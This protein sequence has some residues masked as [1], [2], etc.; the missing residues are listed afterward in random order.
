MRGQDAGLRHGQRGKLG[1][2]GFSKTGGE[3]VCL[4]KLA[5]KLWGPV[6]RAHPHVADPPPNSI[7]LRRAVHSS[8]IVLVGSCVF[9]FI[10]F[11]P[12]KNWLKKLRPVLRWGSCAEIVV[13]EYGV[14]VLSDSPT[15][16]SPLPCPQP[17]VFPCRDAEQRKV[18][19]FKIIYIKKKREGKE[20]IVYISWIL[21]F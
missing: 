20:Y 21:K 11:F 4:L 19:L 9:Y 5:P 15:C 6:P 1:E 18:A 17:L 14:I 2:A 13:P 10:F 7:P 3:E 16:S 8:S 12:P